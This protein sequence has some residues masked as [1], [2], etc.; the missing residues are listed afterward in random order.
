[1]YANFFSSIHRDCKRR[2][3]KSFDQTFVKGHSSSTQ[4]RYARQ[5]IHF[6]NASLWHSLSRRK[7]SGLCTCPPKASSELRLSL[8][9]ES[10]VCHLTCVVILLSQRAIDIHQS[11]WYSSSHRRPVFSWRKVENIRWP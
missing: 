9:T 6:A 1:M 10:C 7:L 5:D 2:R 11:C 3:G 8:G 4:P